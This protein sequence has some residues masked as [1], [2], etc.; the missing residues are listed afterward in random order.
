MGAL[1]AVAVYSPLLAL[2]TITIEGTSRLSAAEIH[3]AVDGQLDTPLALIDF[4][5]ITKELGR[6][7]LIRSYVTEAVPP[8]TLIIHVVERQPIG[9]LAVGSGFTLVDPAGITV[10]TS[11]ERTAGVPLIETG[12][13]STGSTAFSAA[14]EVL[15]A[16]P[17]SMLEKLD[18][19]TAASTDNV[20]LTLVG[21]GAQIIWGSA[22][23]SAYKARVLEAALA[24]FP[25]FS[26]YNVSAPGQL[27][28]R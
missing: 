11:T 17:P 7:P 12:G 28:Y 25:K 20:H 19:I 3:D 5:R 6:F 1:L 4:S 8:N 21:N 15:V 22:E 26:E 2:R 13:Q 24:N 9:Q 18:T 27:T 14:V 23:N 16:L 10:E